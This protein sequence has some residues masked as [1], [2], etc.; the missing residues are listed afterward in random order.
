M[1]QH[2]VKQLH[3]LGMQRQRSG[4]SPLLSVATQKMPP[5]PPAPQ[6]MKWKGVFSPELRSGCTEASKWL[7][8]QRTQTRS[9]MPATV[10]GCQRWRPMVHLKLFFVFMS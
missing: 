9:R 4:A 1:V 6:G 3:H 10:V 8:P 2:P 5:P 7:R